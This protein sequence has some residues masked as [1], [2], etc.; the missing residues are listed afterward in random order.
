MVR[1]RPQALI[2]FL[3]FFFLFFRTMNGRGAVAAVRAKF[4]TLSTTSPSN[5]K[6]VR[7]QGVPPPVERKDHNVTTAGIEE[8][9]LTK[10]FRGL[11]RDH[12]SSLTLSNPETDSDVVFDDQQHIV[13]KGFLL[14]LGREYK[15]WCGARVCICSSWKVGWLMY[16]HA[17]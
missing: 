2:L 6:R 8:V 3:F 9:S 5:K 13:K 17:N 14:K 11:G 7:R 12:H 16:S 10:A 15:T 1:I 4:E